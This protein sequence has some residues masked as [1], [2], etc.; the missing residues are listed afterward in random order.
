[1]ICPQCGEVAAPGPLDV[2][3]LAVVKRR[4]LRDLLAR[5]RRAARRVAAPAPAGERG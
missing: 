5:V 2:R 1:M 3:R 4:G